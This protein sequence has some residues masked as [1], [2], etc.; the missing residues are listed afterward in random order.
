MIDLKDVDAEASQR[1]MQ[2][3]PLWQVAERVVRSKGFAKSKFLMKFLL[4]ICEMH[5]TGRDSELTE[6]RIGEWVFERPEGYR[7][8][9]DNIVRNYAR[10]LRQ[11]L[12]DFFE[13]EGQNEP[14]RIVVPRGAYIPLSVE[15]GRTIGESKAGIAD[16]PAVRPEKERI[17]DDEAEPQ[18]PSPLP[19]TSKERWL[20][21]ALG[22][23]L[24]LSCALSAFLIST[25]PHG[26]KGE[27]RL[28]PSPL[29]SAFF[30]ATRTT[31][32][33]PADT[34]LVIYQE[35]TKDRIHLA[36]YAGEGYQ[37]A[38]SS[39]GNL[40]PD[41]IN[42]LGH[43]RYTSFV[44]LQWIARLAQRPEVARD[45]FQ[46]RYAREVSLDELKDANAIL[47][48]SSDANPWTELFQKDLNFQ[49]E[50]ESAQSNDV[51]IRN[52]HPEHGE[53]K[54]YQTSRSD[55]AH[56]T[57]GLLAVC[58]SL[59]GKGRV[60]VVE[61][62][63]M[64]GTEAAAEYLFSEEMTQLLPHLLDKQGGLGPFEILLQ[65]SNIGANA[66]QPRRI[67]LRI[68]RNALP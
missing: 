10:L 24:A 63:N 14:L 38:S 48:G 61:G 60:L 68:G 44:D 59:D 36:E 31:V 53:Q 22:V 57:Y 49:F 21:R 32:V 58:P 40:P 8:G 3:E 2:E 26:R 17:T 13:G 66:A 46:I 35:L 20:I 34:G 27:T 54:A 37:K 43:R 30:S 25:L 23:A 52:L 12:D 19:G 29:W 67:A 6:Q 64:A 47:F 51:I 4:H 55:P 28:A 7:P 33:I 50:H 1:P 18:S 42:D 15:V 5:L 56:T 16:S 45:R 62:I 65:T 39:P 41:T 11:R 9:D